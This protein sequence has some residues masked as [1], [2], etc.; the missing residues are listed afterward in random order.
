MT[1]HEK[2]QTKPTQNKLTNDFSW[3]MLTTTICL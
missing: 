1:S 2:T 3:L